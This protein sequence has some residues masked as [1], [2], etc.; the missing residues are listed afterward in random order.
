MATSTSTE[1]V[2]LVNH[3][4]PG[5]RDAI[6][7]ELLSNREGGL[8]SPQKTNNVLPSRLETANHINTNSAAS[9]HLT[10]TSPEALTQSPNP[11]INSPQTPASPP[12]SKLRAITV[13]TTLSGISL[14]NTMGSG[15]LISA[16]PTIARD[17]HLP[18]HLLLWP[19]AVYALA[20]GCLLLIFGSIADVVGPKHLWVVGSYLFAAFTVG[21]GVARTGLEVILFR[22]LLGVAVSMCLPTAVSLITGTFARGTWRNVAF[23]MNGAGQ[24]VGFALG[25]V[26][27][28]VFTDTIGWRWAYY[29]MAIISFVLSTAS[30]WSLP[31]HR[32]LT[33]PGS[34]R[35]WTTRLANDID[36][37]GA[38]LMSA[39]L[40]MLLYVLAVVSSSYRKLQDGSI[41]AVLVLSLVLLV[42]FPYW[43]DRQI[44][45]GKPSLI[46]NKLWRSSSFTTVCIAV[47]LAWASLNGIEYFTTL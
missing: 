12:I 14:L 18:P 25:L 11:D 36:W 2:V 38:I 39:A 15:I 22:T 8:P 46:P 41:I 29:M 21:I 19:A 28:G 20:A 45:Q 33:G 26:L 24:P 44:K 9:Q 16:L 23:A 30:I 10:P 37:V 3:E 32:V 5:L 43:M 1:S 31:S 27:G 7:L 13:I 47:F 4:Q 35:K 34:E 6:P 40:G 42:A 17:V